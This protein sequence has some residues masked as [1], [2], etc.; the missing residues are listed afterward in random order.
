MKVSV[1]PIGNSKGIRI[2]KAILQ[3]CHIEKEVELEVENEKVIVSSIKKE[4]RKNWDS[5]FKN[6]SKKKEDQLLIDDII[7]LDSAQWEW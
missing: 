4:I 2:P 1:V 7:D 5:Q 6:M 3:Q